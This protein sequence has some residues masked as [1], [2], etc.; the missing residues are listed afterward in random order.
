MLIK[1]PFNLFLR[2][3]KNL[4]TTLPIPKLM[5]KL[6]WLLHWPFAWVSLKSLSTIFIK[7]TFSFNI[8]SL[9]HRWFIKRRFWS[10]RK[11]GQYRT[12]QIDFQANGPWLCNSLLMCCE[13]DWIWG[14]CDQLRCDW[15]AGKQDRWNSI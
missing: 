7:C 11:R 14:L 8:Q 4:L 2:L 9:S 12:V 6:Q 5:D 1:S 15:S 10:D 13:C 3:A